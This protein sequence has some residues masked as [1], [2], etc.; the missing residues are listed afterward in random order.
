MADVLFPPRTRRSS[1]SSGSAQ[2]QVL[3]T[4]GDGREY[5]AIAVS[6]EG[7][8]DAE[9]FGAA[10]A[11][12]ASDV[13]VPALQTARAEMAEA[14]GLRPGRDAVARWAQDLVDA[15]P[16]ARTRLS[17]AARGDMLGWLVD[18]RVES[19][20]RHDESLVVFHLPP[21]TV[22]WRVQYSPSGEDA[23]GRRNMLSWFESALT[24][25][26]AD[27]SREQVLEFTVY[28]GDNTTI[29]SGELGGG[30]GPRL[31]VTVAT[32]RRQGVATA[33]VF[34]RLKRRSKHREDLTFQPRLAAWLETLD[35]AYVSQYPEVGDMPRSSMS[36][37][38]VFVHG[39][40]A[41]GLAHLNE[42][43]HATPAL[44]GLRLLRYEHDTFLPIR[45]NALDLLAQ[46]TK[47][48][49]G[50][51]SRIVLIG[52]S[53]GGLVAR[54]TAA[55]SVKQGGPRMAVATFGAPHRGTPV[56]RAG[57]RV[58]SGLAAAASAG[59]G[60][61]GGPPLAV[62]GMRYV[63]GHVRKL[64]AG[65]RD[66]AE[67]SNFLLGLEDGYAPQLI[68]AYGA[69][70]KQGSNPAS[71]GVRILDKLG[72]NLFYDDDRRRQPNDLLVSVESATA[73]GGGAQM[74]EACGHFGYFAEPELSDAVA[75]LR[76]QL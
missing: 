33:A 68:S 31:D 17:P 56:V 8:V 24:R 62:A 1:A 75:S 43:A 36:D 73:P 16:Q 50:P 35:A 71:R 18:G 32:D 27:R 57:Q 30:R 70:Y 54:K 14:R 2:W 65:V 41:C 37:V 11:E 49:A 66:M 44:P 23:R 51:N 69:D 28:A 5:P 22:S 76:S 19:V 13:D 59:V 34:S 12:L 60:H 10:L 29:V 45:D 38:V 9:L 53:R 74:A 67:Q 40:L 26:V 46:L 47:I 63:F 39:T 58:L 64:P 4:G 72:R 21:D 55:L 20:V 25:L 15:W 42:L 61:L 3:L 48:T 52:H 7:V 6:R